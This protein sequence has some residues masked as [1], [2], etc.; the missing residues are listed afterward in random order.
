MLPVS[1]VRWITF[2]DK[3]ACGVDTRVSPAATFATTFLHNCFGFVN[4]LLLLTTRQT[5]LLF[6]D[7]KDQKRERPRK[8]PGLGGGKD[9]NRAAGNRFDFDE[10]DWDDRDADSKIAI[11]MH[12]IQPS[13][14]SPSFDQ[15][16]TARRRRSVSQ[17]SSPDPLGAVTRVDHRKVSGGSDCVVNV[18][19]PTPSFIGNSPESTGVRNKATRG[20]TQL[21]KHDTRLQSGGGSVDEYSEEDIERRFREFDSGR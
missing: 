8:E 12:E 10:E 4:V 5:L 7:P 11:L 3:T 16:E 6:D 2:G 19:P 1:I 9:S 20:R 14:G 18:V 13:P 17:D 15:G 21:S